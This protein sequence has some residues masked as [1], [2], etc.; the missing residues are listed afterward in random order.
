L[1]EYPS[2][3]IPKHSRTF[4]HF[5]FTFTFNPGSSV[6][7]VGHPRPRPFIKPHVTSFHRPLPSSTS[8]TSLAE[9]EHYKS[10]R[11]WKLCIC[12][13]S[14][15]AKS[16]L[17]LISAPNRPALIIKISEPQSAPPAILFCNSAARFLQPVFENTAPSNYPTPAPA[18]SSPLTPGPVLSLRLVHRSAMSSPHI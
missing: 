10:I 18:P 14:Q 3:P 12:L 2:F 16:S 7:Q 6:S 1:L 15:S 8:S 11:I 4:L 5:T 9:L 13:P 17:P